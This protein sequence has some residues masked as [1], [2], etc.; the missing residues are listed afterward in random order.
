MS[1]PTIADI[2]AALIEALQDSTA[3]DFVPDDQIV[4][5]GDK[6]DTVDFERAALGLPA[7]LVVY[8]G[9]VSDSEEARRSAANIK[10]WALYVCAESLA[11]EADARTAEQGA[12]AMLDGIFDTLQDNDL[13]LAGLSPFEHVRDERLEADETAIIYGTAFAA[14]AVL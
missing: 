5:F 9:S 2:E 3:L 6:P 14:A 4:S 12:Y 1:R 8:S 11:G 13:G 7:I 10:Q